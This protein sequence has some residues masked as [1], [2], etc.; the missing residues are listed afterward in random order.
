[1]RTGRYV[2]AYVLRI[3]PHTTAA[4][5]QAFVLSRKTCMRTKFDDYASFKVEVTT[6]D[7]YAFFNSDRWPAG[8]Y[9]RL[10]YDRDRAAQP[11]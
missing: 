7:T 11:T 5:M 8:A 4:D 2:A 1:M 10:Y 9:I 3:L 6:E